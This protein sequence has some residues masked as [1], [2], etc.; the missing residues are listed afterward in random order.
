MGR[1]VGRVDLGQV[2]GEDDLRALRHPGEQRLE[3]GHLEVLGLVDDH[4]LVLQGP[5]PQERHRLQGEPVLGHHLV[6]HPAGVGV[7]AVLGEGGDV[8]E[9]GPHPGRELLLQAAGEEAEVGLAV[10]HHR[11][12]DGQLVVAGAAVD[13]RLHHLLEA[14]GEGQDRLARPGEARQ[15]HDGHVGVHQQVEG[16]NLLLGTGVEAPHLAATLDEVQLVA[17]DAGQSQRRPRRQDDVLV[18]DHPVEGGR[19]RH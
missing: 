19:D 2:A 9:D 16:E 3:G 12:V 1:D 17:E 11:P 6:D 10:G 5:A 7:G 8:V 14:G 18:G 15:G 4:E 13:A